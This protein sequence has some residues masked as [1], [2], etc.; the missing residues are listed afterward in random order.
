[1]TALLCGGTCIVRLTRPSWFVQVPNLS[2]HSCSSKGNQV[3]S[4]L[5]VDWK[6]PGGIWLTLPLLV[7]TSKL[8]QGQLSELSAVITVMCHHCQLSSMSADSTVSCHHCQ[9]FLLSAVNTSKLRQCQLAS[10]PPLLYL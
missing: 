3:M 4:T 8:R 7:T 6:M 1:M 2:S 9:L 5:Q 10:L